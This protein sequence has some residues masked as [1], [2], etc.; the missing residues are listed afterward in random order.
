MELKT[1]DRTSELKQRLKEIHVRSEDTCEFWNKKK[2]TQVAVRR[3]FHC[4]YYFPKSTNEN[5]G[6]CVKGIS[7]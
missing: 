4:A 6:F 7:R 5:E 3:C 2:T 1:V